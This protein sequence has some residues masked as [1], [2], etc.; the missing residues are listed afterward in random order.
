MA[1]VTDLAIDLGTSNVLM[2]QKGKNIVLRQPAVVAIERNTKKILAIGADAQ[3]MI[4]RTPGNI[5]ALRPL[6]NGAVADFE[7]TNTMLRHFMQTIIGKRLF[8]R[9]R[10]VLS[11]PSGV[12]E[13]EKSSIVS[14][15]FDAG[16]SR[17]QLLDRP[18]AAAL[19]VGLDFQKPYG[20]MVVDMGAGATDIAVLASGQIIESSCV[21]F[22]GD[23]FDDAII[24]Y[25]RKKHNLLIG[26]RT[27][28]E[29][30]ITIGTAIPPVDEPL[31]KEVTGRDL[32]SGLPKVQAIS[33]AEVYEA[34]KDVV[35]DLA[36]AIYEVLRHT[37]P[38][39][40]SDISEDGIVLTGGAAALSGLPEAIYAALHIPCG[41]AKDPQTTVVMGCGIALDNPRK[42]QAILNDGRRMR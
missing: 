30:K 12:S 13:A 31:T 34:I 15:L 5:L 19:G 20:C 8:A 32:L 21:H 2:Y 6:K 17:T 1:K 29:L 41:V 28:E 40:A 33:S 37:P 14:I 22:G 42:Y 11:V 16:A 24:R 23:Y 18:I 25:L 3:R 39:L 36:E 27:A 7:L 4:G 9:P 26:E 38:Q 35:G 10:V